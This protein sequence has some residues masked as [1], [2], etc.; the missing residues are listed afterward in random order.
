MGTAD[1]FE[2]VENFCRFAPSQQRTASGAA[3]RPRH[4]EGGHLYIRKITS[5]FDEAHKSRWARCNEH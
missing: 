1:L 4:R 5:L 2:Q 3:R